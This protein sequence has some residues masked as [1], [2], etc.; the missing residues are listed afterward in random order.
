MLKEICWDCDRPVHKKDSITIVIKYFSIRRVTKQAPIA[1]NGKYFWAT[2]F[3]SIFR[4]CH[5]ERDKNMIEGFLHADNSAM[6]CCKKRGNVPT[7]SIF[8]DGKNF[9]QRKKSLN[10]IDLVFPPYFKLR[11]EQYC[12]IRETQTIF[13]S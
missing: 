12:Y 5:R 8:Y 11:I 3:L 6:Q 4:R 13:C 10:S 2:V 1:I 9:S 7:M